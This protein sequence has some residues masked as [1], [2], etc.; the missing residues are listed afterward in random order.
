M[1]EVLKQ[2]EHVPIPVENQVTIFYLATAGHLDDV[3][4]ERV[5][6]FESAWYEYAEMNVPG[7]LK[8][9]RES[10]AL[11]EES[12]KRLDE[13]VAAYKQTTAPRAGT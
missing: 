6:A 7:V 11:S 9:I 10:G 8:D 1:T 5:S 13:A 2:P 12:Q 4:V 3:A